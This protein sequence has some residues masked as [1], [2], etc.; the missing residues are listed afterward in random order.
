MPA[1]K[2]APSFTDLESPTN[3]LDLVAQ[4]TPDV[5]VSSLP[6]SL[7][8]YQGELESLLGRMFSGR[9]QST[10]NL[11]LAQQMTMNWCIS[12]WR[13]IGIEVKG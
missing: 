10:H 9:P 2:E 3:F 4:A 12:K 7:S 1:I 8:A 5:W 6:P 11:E 13:K